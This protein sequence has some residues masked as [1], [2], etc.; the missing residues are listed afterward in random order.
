MLGCHDN[1]GSTSIVFESYYQPYT[2]S[3]H[4]NE[5]C[6]WCHSVTFPAVNQ[7]T[8][9][10]LDAA[11]VT[12]TDPFAAC[13]E[14]H[15][16][17]LLVEHDLRQP[18]TCSTCHNSADATVLSAI[19]GSDTSCEAC[20]GNTDHQSDHFGGLSGYTGCDANDC[21]VDNIMSEHDGYTCAICHESANPNVQ[22]AV[23]NGVA[24]CGACHPGVPHYGGFSIESYVS[25]E[26]AEKLLESSVANSCSPCHL[27]TNASTDVKV[28]EG[29]RHGSE[30]YC[31]SWCHTSSVHGF[32]GSDYAAMRTAML[33]ENADGLIDAAVASSVSNAPVDGT[34]YNTNGSYLATMTVYNPGVTSALMNDTGTDMLYAR[35]VGTGYVCANGGCHINGNFNSTTANATWGSWWGQVIHSSGDQYS[36]KYTNSL[37]TVVTVPEGDYYPPY[38]IVDAEDGLTYD[39]WDIMNMRDGAVKGHTLKA[40]ADMT[41]RDVAFANV[42]RCNFCHDTIDYR[43]SNTT[44]QFPHGNDVIL[45]DGTSPQVEALNHGVPYDPPRYGNDT[46]AAWFTL[47]ANTGDTA[48]I[49]NERFPDGSA[50]STYTVGMD[51]AC[52]KCHRSSGDAAGIGIS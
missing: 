28:S 33:T 24:Q 27:G 15:D 39:L 4:I 42:G 14:C 10:S 20:H 35:S 29:N 23:M 7:H 2:Y 50:D 38:E 31:A 6:S 30:G 48:I 36:P 13:E 9:I 49:T 12:T 40:V 11:H 44:K 52:L 51:G 21:H 34:I 18:F 43:I 37:G 8:T 46:N 47:K 19:D 5:E 1:S 32:G 41:V 26:K 17:S 22:S 45:P 3:G 25:W 16:G